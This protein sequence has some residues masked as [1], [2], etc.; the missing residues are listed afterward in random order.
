MHQPHDLARCRVG[1]RVLVSVKA[2]A[3]VAGLA[4][5][6]H[7]LRFAAHDVNPGLGRHGLEEA[8]SKPQQQRPDRLEQVKLLGSHGNI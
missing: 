3:Q 1:P 7:A 5:V 4:D 8:R 2:F 6:K